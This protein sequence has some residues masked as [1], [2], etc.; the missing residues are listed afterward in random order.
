MKPQE[1]LDKFK[2]LDMDPTDAQKVQGCANRLKERGHLNTG[3]M[4]MLEGILA[5]SQPLPLKKKT[6]DAPTPKEK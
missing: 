1:L 5:R 6:K 2:G 3:Q 4:D